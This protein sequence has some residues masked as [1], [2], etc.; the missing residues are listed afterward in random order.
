MV[1]AADQRAVVLDHQHRVA[2]RREIAQQG[3]QLLAVLRVEADRRLVEHVEG[4]G[5]AGAEG[6]GEVDALRLAAGEGARLAIE[7]QIVEPHPVEHLDALGQLVEQVAGH[8]ALPGRPWALAQ[9]GAELLEAE[10]RE[11]RQRPPLQLDGEGL[12]LQAGAEALRAEVVGAVAG[13]QHAHVHLVGALLQPVEEVLQAGGVAGAAPDPLAVLLGELHPGHVEGDLALAAGGE[14]LVVELLVGRGV[15]RRERP[16]FEGAPGVRDHPLAV[17]A[18]HPAEPLALRAGA[19][20]GVERE[21]GRGGPARRL[22]A[23]R[24]GELAAVEAHPG[25]PAGLH[26]AAVHPVP[27]FERVEDAR[28]GRGLRREAAEDE[29]Q[30]IALGRP[31]LARLHAHDLLPLQTA[32]EALADQLAEGVVRPLL[33]PRQAHDQGEGVAGRAGGEIRRRVLGAVAADRAVPVDAPDLPQV[34][35][36]EAHHVERLGDRAHRRA[37]VADGV[38]GLERHRRQDVVDGVHRR[39]FHLIEELPRVGGHRLDEAALPLGEDGVEG[40]RGLARSRRAGHHGHRAMRHP[41]VDPLQIVGA[42]AFD[43]DGWVRGSGH[44]FPAAPGI[45]R[46]RSS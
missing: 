31:L 8:L 25:G 11:L 23:D 28:L 45:G 19:E 43:Q 10:G 20:R 1:G 40:E 35:E 18:D 5:E 22:A 44:R 26:P 33:R 7:G 24:A 29:R 4:A 37:G 16:L 12:G 36:E 17:D 32:L 2:A 3:E 38:L 42:G 39:A 9:P 30:G 13:E 41:A 34:G 14:E 21:Q 15:P 46:S 27:L 6:G